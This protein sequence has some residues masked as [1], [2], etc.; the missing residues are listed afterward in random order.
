M[1]SP[2]QQ[3]QRY[4]QQAG[5]TKPLRDHLFS[6]LKLPDPY[7]MLDVGCGTGALA[8][9][10]M[11]YS[12]ALKVG[13]DI[14]FPSLRFFQSL[15]KAFFLMQ[16][17]GFQLPFSSNSFHLCLCHFLLLWVSDPLQ[18]LREMHRVTCMGGYV[19][20][21]A[22][23]DYGGRIDY[24]P[25]L[26]VAGKLQSRALQR[27]GADVMIGRK[28]KSLLHRAGFE[29]LE[30]G[31]LGGQWSSQT[32]AEGSKLEWET[33]Q[34]DVQ[35]LIAPHELLHLKEVV[36]Q[37]EKEHERVLFIPTFYAFAQKSSH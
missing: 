34:H 5:W 24:P 23:P 13:I 21:L 19:L 14:H 17:D 1:L 31:V 2:E 6:R 10:L 26:E 15:T 9:D 30:S 32:E 16:A 20:I 25:H 22:E 36:S 11:R 33:F 12:S 37:A 3:H 27:R 18:V 7:S 35:G 4:T 8:A 29:V 28:L